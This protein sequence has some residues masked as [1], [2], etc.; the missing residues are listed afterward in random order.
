ML[1]T[2]K[3]R[4]TLQSYD[5]TAVEWLWGAGGPDRLCF[6]DLEMKVLSLRLPQKSTIVEIGCG[7]ATDGKYLEA[8]GHRAVC[9]DYSKS[10]V[11]IAKNLRPTAKVAQ[12][13]L[14][15]M[16]F[17]ANS[18]DGF[19]ASATLLHLQNPQNA[20][21]EIVRV[22]KD[23][24]F[25]FISIKEGDGEIVDPITGYYFKYYNNKA[26]AEILKNAGFDIV[27]NA[28][29]PGTQGHDWLTFLVRVNKW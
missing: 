21:K 1:L 17:S 24:G 25:G 28:K 7:P 5:S 10:M 3:E 4:R 29:R 16:G 22:T 13:N 27:R 8:L 15:E 26:F 2:E 19:W 20:I 12:M 6:W 23:K 9:F 14:Y 11:A 18:F